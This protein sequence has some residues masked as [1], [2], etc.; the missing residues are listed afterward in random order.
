MA[1]EAQVRYSNLVDLKLRKTLVK[2]VGVICNNRYEGSP[3]AGSVKVP[4]RDTEVVVNDYDKVK[5]AK[6]TSG[7]TTY[8]TVNIDHDKAVNEII[9]GFDAESVPG[10]LVADRLDS[11]GYSLGLQMDSDGSVELTT[12]GTAFGNTTALTEKTIYANIVDARTQQS[13]IGVPTAGRWLLV[14]P[15]TYGLLLKSPEF[16]KASDLGDAVVQTGAV[17]KIAGY[18]V[19]EDSTLGENVEYVAGHPNWFAVI[20]EWAV[21]VHLQD[22][23][24]SGDFI[25]RRHPRQEARLRKG[26]AMLYCTYDEYQAAGGTV[27]EAAFGVLCSRAS[28][29]IDSATFGRAEA[30]AAGC[31]DCRQMLADACAQIVDLFAAQAAV[32]AVPGAASVSNDGWSVSFSANSS[33]SA[34]VRTEAWHVL[35]NALGADPHGLLY[36]GCF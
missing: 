18:T 7:D 29:L 15:D 13:S 34:A 5:G 20:D 32:G 33:L 14:S 17:G 27:P 12:A 4:V 24:G 10:D 30:H 2:K 11:A 28:R 25:G 23:S 22:L 9:D 16:I 3:K 6:Q 36:R 35:E 19:F 26:A 8:L 31:E 21:P 1:H